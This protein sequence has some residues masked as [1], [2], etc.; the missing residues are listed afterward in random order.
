MIDWICPF[1]AFSVPS[2]PSEEPPPVLDQHVRRRHG[3]ATIQQS[4]LQPRETVAT[5]AR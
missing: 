2:V 1:C 5:T 3:P 4:P